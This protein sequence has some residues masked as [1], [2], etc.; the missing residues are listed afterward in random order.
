M[1]KAAVPAGQPRSLRSIAQS[2]NDPSSFADAIPY[3]AQAGVPMS[4]KGAGDKYS[5]AAMAVTQGS[6]MDRADIP[7]PFVVTRSAKR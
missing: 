3:N 6:V 4:S 2:Q 7:A 5:D 1:F